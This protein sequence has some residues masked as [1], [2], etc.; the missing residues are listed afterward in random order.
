[1]QYVGERK[2]MCGE[3]ISSAELNIVLASLCGK[4]EKGRRFL[5]SIN[6]VLGAE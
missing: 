3:R 6:K 2:L 1:M 4:V 5:V